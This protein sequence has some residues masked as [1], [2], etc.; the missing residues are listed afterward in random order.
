MDQMVNNIELTKKK[1]WMLETYI[2]YNSTMGFSK[3]EFYNKLLDDITLLKITSSITPQKLP[4]L[5]N[6]IFQ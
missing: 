5:L 3:H 2:T 6:H 1:A 4:H